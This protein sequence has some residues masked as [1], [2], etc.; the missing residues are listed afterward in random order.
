MGR[1]YRIGELAKLSGVSIRALRFYEEAG[2]LVP[3]RNAANGYRR[4]VA[5]DVDRLQEI[6]LLRSLGVPV[7]EIGPLLSGSDDERRVSLAQHLEELK[8]KRERLSAIIAT[9]ERTLA[10]LEGGA[11]VSDREKF[12]GFARTVVEENERQY[13]AEARERY[14]DEAVDESNRKVLGMSTQD[15]D[16][17]QE[18]EAE[19]RRMLVDAVRTNADPAGELGER[20]CD[21]HRRWLGYTWPSYSAEAHRGLAES[22]VCDERFTAYYDREVPGC[23]AWLRDAIVAHARS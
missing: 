19:I 1:G 14:G 6:V 12:E 15:Y 16:A 7:R 18:L 4:Y 9:V 21:L 22:Y 8:A 13:G 17:W 23:A 20:V 3:Q 5:A 2:L 10:G 11:E